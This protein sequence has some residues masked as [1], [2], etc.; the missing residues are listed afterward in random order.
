MSTPTQSPSLTTR[1]QEILE[2]IWQGKHSKEI[3]AQLSISTKTVEAH[4]A[5]MAKKFRV[6][7]TAQLL[8]VALE[9]GLLEISR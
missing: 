8:R 2:L 5:N 7:N 9:E 1:E 4:R 6:N 3:A